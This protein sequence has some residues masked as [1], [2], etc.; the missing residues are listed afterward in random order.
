MTTARSFRSRRGGEEAAVFTGILEIKIR[1]LD[2][3]Q[4]KRGFKTF[5]FLEHGRRAERQ[6]TRVTDDLGVRARDL[7]RELAHPGPAY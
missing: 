2:K 5:V 7:P 4:T 3:D 1:Y 6:A